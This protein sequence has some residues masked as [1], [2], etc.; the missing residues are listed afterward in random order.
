MTSS[1]P[2]LRRVA[3][4]ALVG[5]TIEYYDFFSYGTAAALVFGQVFFPALGAA[6]GLL[7]AFS[8]YAVAFLARP[9]GAVLFGHYG[10]RLGRKT[11]LVGSLLL[12]GAPP[13]WSGCCRATGPGGSGR[14]CCWSP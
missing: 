7:A 1:P 2:A 5:T 6:G 13:R 11:T 14:R 8:V 12:M 3:T 10:D 9:V 4:A